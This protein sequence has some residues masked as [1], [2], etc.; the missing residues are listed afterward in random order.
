MAVGNQVWSSANSYNHVPRTA[1]ERLRDTPR[2]LTVL[3]AEV[4]AAAG[5]TGNTRG[6]VHLGVDDHRS[7]LGEEEHPVSPQHERSS[8]EGPP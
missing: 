1:N 6:T 8:S 3:V 5:S 7:S 4:V 2:S